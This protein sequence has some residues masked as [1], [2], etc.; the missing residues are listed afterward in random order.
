MYRPRV[1]GQWFDGIRIYA[2]ASSPTRSRRTCAGLRYAYFSSIHCSLYVRLKREQGQAEVFDG[3]EAPHPQEIFLQRAD[4]ALRHAVTFGR[5]HKARGTLNPEERDLLLE[6]GGQVVRPVVVTQ[7]Q[8]A[9]GAVAD[10]AE[11]FADTLADGLQGL[12]AVAALGRLQ[13]DALGRAVCAAR[14]RYA[15]GP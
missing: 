14:T 13:T 1:L 3:L 6:I 8:P 15:R 5:S 2:A 10:P 7:P 4:E 11:A 9:G 12:E